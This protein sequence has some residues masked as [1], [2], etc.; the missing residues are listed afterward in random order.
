MK[1]LF[2]EV[3]ASFS[4]VAREK[5]PSVVMLTDIDF[6]AQSYGS[7]ARIASVL[8]AV[9]VVCDVTIFSFRTLTPEARD[10][11][12]AL[13]LKSKLMSYKDVSISARDVSIEANISAWPCIRSKAH[14]DWMQAAKS[15]LDNRRPDFVIIEYA[16]RSYLLDAVPD[17]TKTILDAHDVMSERALAFAR[18]GKTAAISLTAKE[19]FGL[20]SQYDA[21]LAISPHDAT[22]M[23]ERLGLENILNVPHAAIIAEAAPVRRTARKLLF[24][25]ANSEANIAGLTWFVDQVWPLLRSSHELHIVG[26]VCR[27]VGED[28]QSVV[29]HGFVEDLGGLHRDCDL[30]VNPVFVGGGIKIKTL[31]A[32]SYGVPC[33]TTREGARGLEGAVGTGLIVARNRSE[34]AASILALSTNGELRES[35]ARTGRE[36]IRKHHYPSVVFRDLLLFLRNS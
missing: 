2:D 1:T 33:V 7:H 23:R 27:S 35:I 30:V 28:M 3:D 16:D 6:W 18:I 26:S 22:V 17:Q 21:V 25:G 12:D 8:R 4:R 5:K 29:R 13:G 32:M 11:F 14:V 36:Y 19:E 15:F 10:Q 20:L 24:T 31:E 34:F 9:E